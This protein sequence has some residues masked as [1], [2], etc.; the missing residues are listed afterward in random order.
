LA[1]C[2]LAARRQRWGPLDRR[3]LQWVSLVTVLVFATVLLPQR[4]LLAARLDPTSNPLEGR[5]VAE[6][7]I[8][9][10]VALAL[11]ADRPLLGVG[12]GNYVVAGRSWHPELL[13]EVPLQPA[14]NLFLL[15]AAETGLLGGLAWLVL[16]L[17]PLRVVLRREPVPLASVALAA[18]PLALFVAGL[19][20]H[21]VWTRFQVQ[22]LLAL[23]LASFTSSLERDAVT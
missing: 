18:A 2:W 15:I 8:D 7:A 20:D 11:I 6:R 21:Y 4:E 23:L 1:C 3:Q 17:Q 19:F 22:I 16:C 13:A 5:S 12:G 9:L 14:H 10:R